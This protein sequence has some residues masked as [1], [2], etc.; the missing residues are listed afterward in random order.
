MF[1][2]PQYPLSPTAR[3]A[4]GIEVLKHGLVPWIEGQAKALR[5]DLLDAL[6][7]SSPVKKHGF[8]LD[9]RAALV[10]LRHHHEAF[11]PAE[12]AAAGRR[13]AKQVLLARDRWA[14]QQELS[15]RDV[16]EALITAAELIGMLGRGP[17]ARTL[18]AISQ[19]PEQEV[20]DVVVGV[21]TDLIDTG[22]AQ[23]LDYETFE[24]EVLA[25]CYDQT[26]RDVFR[27]LQWMCAMDVTTG[28]PLTV[29]IIT[30]GERALSLDERD[31]PR[32]S[33]WW[34][35]GC[36]YDAD[37]DVRRTG[38]SEARDYIDAEQVRRYGFKYDD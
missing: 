17:A 28:A 27:A 19:P 7:P 24:S 10:V 18:D 9:A 3:M 37:L 33:F 34:A 25:A 22:G 2:E 12:S 14:H 26:E 32:A 23:R 36:A 11:F 13:G 1:A 31:F 5:I 6:P 35:F 21:R 8:Q 29:A 16:S 30:Q 4:C 38:L 20:L 15:H